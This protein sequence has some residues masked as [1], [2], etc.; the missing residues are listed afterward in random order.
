M[1]KVRCCCFSHLVFSPD[2]TDSSDIRAS[3]TT[4]RDGDRDSGGLDASGYTW[5]IDQT[6]TVRR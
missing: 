4:V 5:L 3:T 6:A 1:F 2:L